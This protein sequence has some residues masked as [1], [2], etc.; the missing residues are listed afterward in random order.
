MLAMD[1]NLRGVRS[2]SG[3]V[4]PNSSSIALTMSGSAKESSRPLS[5]R[6]S[7]GPTC[8]GCLETFWMMPTIRV[9]RSSGITHQYTFKLFLA[10]WAT[11]SKVGRSGVGEQPRSSAYARS[12]GLRSARR[13]LP[14]T[15]VHRDHLPADHCAIL[16]SSRVQMD[17]RLL[18]AGLCPRTKTVPV[19]FDQ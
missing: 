10:L 6:E 1:S 7:S 14:R 16:F 9:C 15:E 3:T 4:I 2:E 17:R 19:T 8:T 5:N 13:V 11:G 18:P 12:M